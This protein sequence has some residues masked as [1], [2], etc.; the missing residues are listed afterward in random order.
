MLAS[1]YQDCVKAFNLAGFDDLRYLTEGLWDRCRGLLVSGSNIILLLPQYSFSDRKQFNETKGILC[2]ASKMVSANSA[3]L[4]LCL[5]R[6][7]VDALEFLQF[8]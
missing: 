2:N 4:F 5:W 7:S 3:L 8:L 1:D 6:T